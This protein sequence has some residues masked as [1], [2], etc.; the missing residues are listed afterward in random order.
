[1]I[2]SKGNDLQKIQSSLP[3]LEERSNLL[4]EITAP[5]LMNPPSRPAANGIAFSI[6][7][8]LDSSTVTRPTVHLNTYLIC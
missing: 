4:T 2:Y 3:I 1:M 6:V 7:G 8:V 5:P